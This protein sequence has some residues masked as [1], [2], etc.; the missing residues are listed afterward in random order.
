MMKRVGAGLIAVL[1]A[2]PACGGVGWWDPLGVTRAG[3]VGGPAAGFKEAV[4]GAAGEGEL[5]D[6]G[7]AAFGVVGD[8]MDFAV[9]AGH[10]A[11]RGRAA[12][13]VGVQHDSLAGGGQPL[14][15]IQRQG[16]ALIEDG[17]IVDGRGGPAGSRR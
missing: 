7:G 2:P 11:A 10:G 1:G 16:F 17:Q 6:V 8:V 4:V 15:V 9:V 13:V 5:V 14:G 3:C 12:A